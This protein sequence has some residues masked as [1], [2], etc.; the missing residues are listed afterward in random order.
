MFSVFI[1]SNLKYLLHYKQTLCVVHCVAYYGKKNKQLFL[2][3]VP[4][5]VTNK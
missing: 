2:V 5:I 3:F 1:I 4:V